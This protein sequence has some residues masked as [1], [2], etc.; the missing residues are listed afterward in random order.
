MPAGA[1]KYDDLCTAARVET[2]AE[3]VLLVIL[4]GNRGHGFS[5]QQKSHVDP[6]AIVQ[7][8][9]DVATEIET[10]IQKRRS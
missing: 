10:S 8:L 3:M 4:G 6:L 9:R 2:D 5:M 1:G 7:M